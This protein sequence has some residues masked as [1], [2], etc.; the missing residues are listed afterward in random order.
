LKNE[1]NEKISNS[2]ELG[3]EIFT[4]FTMEFTKDLDK[5]IPLPG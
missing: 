4:L 3:E 1:F 2:H 5:S